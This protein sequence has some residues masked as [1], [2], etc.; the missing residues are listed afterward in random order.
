MPIDWNPHQ[1][2][3][4]RLAVAGAFTEPELTDTL[5]RR[6]NI[7]FFSLVDRNISFQ[8]KCYYLIEYLNSENLIELFIDTIR[9]ERSSNSGISNLLFVLKL[10]ESP[11]SIMYPPQTAQ[12]SGRKN[13][14]EDDHPN[15]NRRTILERKTLTSNIITMNEI[16]SI[17]R[18]ICRIE[19]RGNFHGTGFL[20]ADNLVLTNY[21]VIEDSIGLS[22]DQIRC[23]F[24]FSSHYPDRIARLVQEKWLVKSSPYAAY[25]DGIDEE[26]PTI[27][28]LDFAVLRMAEYVGQDTAEKG[29]PRGVIDIRNRK[30][31]KPGDKIRV[32]QYAAGNQLAESHG[33]LLEAPRF[34]MRYN[35]STDEGSSGSPVLD[36]NLSVVALHHA[37]DPRRRTH[38]EYNQGVPIYLIA[39]VLLSQGILPP[40]YPPLPPPEPLPLPDRPKT[41]VLLGEPVNASGP[42]AIAG[43]AAL[44]AAAAGMTP[45]LALKQWGDG[46]LDP[47]LDVAAR[48]LL[49]ESKPVFVR[50][51]ADPH[52]KVDASADD[53]VVKLREHLA[54]SADA[55]DDAMPRRQLLAAP[56]VLWRPGRVWDKLARPP[57]HA[58]NGTAPELV[59]W[60]ASTIDPPERQA[61]EIYLHVELPSSDKMTSDEAQKIE[62]LEQAIRHSLIEA[63]GQPEPDWRP[64]LPSEGRV[65]QVVAGI[66]PTGVRILA[67]SDYFRLTEPTTEALTIEAFRGLN[68][69]IDNGLERAAGSLRLLRIAVLVRSK[70]FPLMPEFNGNA[71]LP[72][73][74]L[75]QMTENDDG[76]IADPAQQSHIRRKIAS[77]RTLANV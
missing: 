39:D 3:A 57:I 76:Y 8:K 16:A 17:Q 59:Q 75:L 77:V 12:E 67:L 40:T 42:P 70:N 69:Q 72:N 44:G 38:A 68:R 13:I 33:D 50:L 6:M 60:L 1:R 61:N 14:P 4:I 18:R 54:I 21:H 36:I 31:Y 32:Y 62:R 23:V 37:G 55:P 71:R 25:D 49:F 58:S 30:N 27:E 24:D 26:P 35:A 53:L 47:P 43:L 5:Y 45:P 41:I 10:A 28:Q 46:W 63:A 65:S 48:D 9:D 29:A 7:N 52:A 20:I 73:W 19:S 34:R 66:P 64:F 15:Q 56:A 22:G 11:K 74:L 51:I 2:E